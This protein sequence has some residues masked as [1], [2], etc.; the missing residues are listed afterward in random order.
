M[1]VEVLQRKKICQSLGAVWGGLSSQLWKMGRGVSHIQGGGSTF[2]WDTNSF[3]HYTVWRP[4]RRPLIGQLPWRPENTLVLSVFSLKLWS[5]RSVRLWQ[6]VTPSCTMQSGFANTRAEKYWWCH[7]LGIPSIPEPAT[8]LPAGP[9]MSLYVPKIQVLHRR[10]QKFCLWACAAL[11]RN[12]S[13]QV[14]LKW[15]Q[16]KRNRV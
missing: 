7:V 1:A 14:T 10:L 15:N 5:S 8:Q 9:F 11:G 6:T 4:K 16:T 2:V 12:V 13:C 3:N